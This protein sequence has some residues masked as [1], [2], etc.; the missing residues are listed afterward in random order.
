MYIFWFR[1]PPWYDAIS[2]DPL[3]QFLNL[4]LFV[5]SVFDYPSRLFNNSRNSFLAMALAATISSVFKNRALLGSPGKK[6]NRQM[7]QIIVITPQNQEKQPPRYRN[8]MF[9]IANRIPPR[10]SNNSKRWCTSNSGHLT[11]WLLFRCCII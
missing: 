7:P 8:I 2:I 4:P 1:R 9:G 10:L 3:H 11:H 5:V 6:E